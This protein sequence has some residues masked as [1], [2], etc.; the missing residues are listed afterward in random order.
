MFKGRRLWDVAQSK[1]SKRLKDYCSWFWDKYSKG[2]WK[3][4]P[5]AVLVE[6]VREYLKVPKITN[7]NN[8]PF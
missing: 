8:L 5:S 1:D 2:Q 7:F 4:Q 6:G 3:G